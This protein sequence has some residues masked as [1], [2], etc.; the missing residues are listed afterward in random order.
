MLLS[1]GGTLENDPVLQAL[2]RVFPDVVSAVLAGELRVAAPLHNRERPAP[3]ARPEL[4]LDREQTV[5]ELSAVAA[6]QYRA[7][8][9]AHR[10]RVYPPPAAAPPRVARVRGTLLG[11]PDHPVPDFG[12]PGNVA[13]E[14]G[15]IWPTTVTETLQFIGA[16]RLR[17]G[18][19]DFFYLNKVE[20]FP[21]WD[22]YDGWEVVTKGSAR[23]EHLMMAHS[24]VAHM[25]PGSPT[26]FV[27]ID[28]WAAHRD[29]YHMIRKLRFFRDFRRRKALLGW[30]SGHRRMKFNRARDRISAELFTAQ[31]VFGQALVRAQWVLVHLRELRFAPIDPSLTYSVKMMAGLYTAGLDRVTT[32]IRSALADIDSEVAKLEEML[33]TQLAALDRRAYEDRPRD[34]ISSWRVPKHTF[35]AEV[36]AAEMGVARVPTFRRTV[37][38]LFVQEMLQFATRV[39][40]LDLA[41]AINPSTISGRGLFWVLPGDGEWHQNSGVLRPT[42]TE[43]LDIVRNRYAELSSAVFVLCR[44]YCNRH[45]ALRRSHGSQPASLEREFVDAICTAPRFVESLRT[46]ETNLASDFDAVRGMLVEQ[47]WVDDVENFVDD[48]TEKQLSGWTK[49]LP[50]IYDM[51]VQINAWSR[52]LASVGL[53]R[54]SPRMIMCLDNRRNATHLIPRLTAISHDLDALLVVYISSNAQRVQEEIAAN[55]KLL[56]AA[57]SM[58]HPSPV[59]YTRFVAGVASAQGHVEQFTDEALALEELHGEH[60]RIRKEFR[61]TPAG[62]LAECLADLSATGAEFFRMISAGNALREAL[63][64]TM[65]HKL[66]VRLDGARHLVKSIEL[67]LQRPPF[68]CP[69]YQPLFV[70]DELRDVGT[71]M[72]E[73]TLE[74]REIANSLRIITGVTEDMTAFDNGARALDLRRKIWEHVN[75]CRKALNRFLSAPFKD[76]DV[77]LIVKK[78]MGWRGDTHDLL[79][80]QKRELTRITISEIAAAAAATAVTSPLQQVQIA[81]VSL[82]PSGRRVSLDGTRPF[83]NAKPMR[84][85]RGSE[86]PNV[87]AGAIAP[88]PRRQRRGTVL[89]GDS[90]INAAQEPDLPEDAVLLYV[91]RILNDTL[92]I[93]PILSLLADKAIRPR[94]WKTLFT[95]LGR[96]YDPHWKFTI[97]TLKACEI[98]SFSPLVTRLNQLAKLEEAQQRELA[99]IKLVWGSMTIPRLPTTVAIPQLPRAPPSV[100]WQ[101]ERS[102]A[103][104]RWRQVR[105]YMLTAV[106]E[107]KQSRRANQDSFV[108]IT[109]FFG[110]SILGPAGVDLLGDTSELEAVILEHS[111][112]MNQVLLSASI[113]FKTVAEDWLADFQSIRSALA[114][115]RSVED[116]WLALAGY[117]ER[118]SFSAVLGPNAAEF[119]AIDKSY[120]AMSKIIFEKPLAMMLLSYHKTDR[121]Y[122]PLQGDK[123]ADELC[124][125]WSRL[126]V[127][128]KDIKADCIEAA[129]ANSPRLLML[130]DAEL[131]RALA[132]PFVPSSRNHA[133]LVQC[134]NGVLRFGC[135]RVKTKGLVMATHAIYQVDKLI[136]EAGEEVVFSRPIMIAREGGVMQWHG[137][138]VAAMQDSLRQSLLDCLAAV[139]GKPI[140]GLSAT[141]YDA[142]CAAWPSQTLLIAHEVAVVRCVT[143]LYASGADESA[144]DENAVFRDAKQALSELTARWDQRL[145]SI[146]SSTRAN[147]IT[148][149]HRARAQ[150]LF[151]AVLSQRDRLRTL[152]ADD[153]PRPESFAWQRQMRY[154]IE[155]PPSGNR[156]IECTVSCLGARQR[157]SFEF[158]GRAGVRL[159]NTPLTERY[160]L[161]IALAVQG[162]SAPV[163]SGAVGAGRPEMV[164]HAAARLGRYLVE[165]EGSAELTCRTLTR[166]LEGVIRVGAWFLLRSVDRL[167][168]GAQSLVGTELLKL[169]W[170]GASGSR[171]LSWL[172]TRQFVPSGTDHPGIILTAD[173]GSI[174]SGRCIP[175]TD[176]LN[177]I[178]RPIHMVRPELGPVL[179]VELQLAGFE[180]VRELSAKL[181]T[182]LAAARRGPVAVWQPVGLRF[183]RHVIKTAATLPCTKVHPSESSRLREALEAAMPAISGF[184]HSALCEVLDAAFTGATSL[185]FSQSESPI[186]P[187][188]RMA[189]VH[190]T[191]APAVIDQRIRATIDG[192]MA[193]YGLHPSQLQVDKLVKMLRALETGRD[194]L[195]YGPAGAGKTTLLRVLAAVARAQADSAWGETQNPT[196]GSI[197]APPIYVEHLYPSTVGLAALLGGTDPTTGA[198]VDGLIGANVR[199]SGRQSRV[200]RWLVC[201]G[202]LQPAW[203]EVISSAIKDDRRLRLSSGEQLVIPQTVTFMFE[204]GNLEDG[205]PALLQNVSAIHIPGTAVSGSDVLHAWHLSIAADFPEVYSHNLD[206]VTAAVERLVLPTARLLEVQH[207]VE[208]M[209]AVLVRTYLTI[210]A[211]VIRDELELA[212]LNGLPRPSYHKFRALLSALLAFCYINVIQSRCPYEREAEFDR[213]LRDQLGAVFPSLALPATGLLVQCVV[214]ST[215]VQL[216]LPSSPA[217]LDRVAITPTESADTGWVAT[218]DCLSR[219]MLVR[220]LLAS[221]VPVLVQGPAGSGKTA[222]VRHICAATRQP[223]ARYVELPFTSTLTGATTRSMLV[224]SLC[225]HDPAHWHARSGQT[226]SRTRRRNLTMFVDDIQSATSPVDDGG[227]PVEVLRQFLDRQSLHDAHSRARS[228][229]KPKFIIARTTLPGSRFDQGRLARFMRHIFVIRHGYSSEESITAI[230]APMLERWL[231]TFTGMLPA[232]QLASL[233]NVIPH[234]MVATTSA[235]KLVQPVQ[236][237]NGKGG[238]AGRNFVF[239]DLHKIAQIITAVTT[240][241]PSSIPAV[242][243]RNNGDGGGDESEEE[244]WGGGFDFF[245]DD[246]D[247]PEILGDPI[248]DA[249]FLVPHIWCREAR[250]AFGPWF[251]AVDRQAWLNTTLGRCANSIAEA[252]VSSIVAPKAIPAIP[253]PLWWI[254]TNDERTAWQPTSAEHAV[255]KFEPIAATIASADSAIS[256]VVPTGLASILDSVCRALS[257]GRHLILAGRV[258]SSQDVLVRLAAHV[259]GLELRVVHPPKDGD[260]AEFRQ[261][262]LGIT[263]AASRPGARHQ[264][265]MVSA[266][267]SLTEAM[268]SDLGALV[269]HSWVPGDVDRSVMT[270]VDVALRG[271][272]VPIAPAAGGSRGMMALIS[273]AVCV[274]D[275]DRGLDSCS[276]PAILE[277]AP[278]L[279]S[280]AT[281]IRV[282]WD[283]DMLQQLAQGFINRLL[284]HDPRI[285]GMFGGNDDDPPVGATLGSLL[286]HVHGQ[287]QDSSGIGALADGLRFSALLTT[288]VAL[289]Q[290][291]ARWLNH[292]IK[293]ARMLIERVS[294]ANDIIAEFQA[295]IDAVIPVRNAATEKCE[296]LYHAAVAKRDALAAVV[297]R[298]IETEKQQATQRTKIAELRAVLEEKSA[299]C[300]LMI[301][302]AVTGLLALNVH[303][304]IEISEYHQPPA[305]VVLAVSPL[306]LLFR[307]YWPEPVFAASDPRLPPAGAAPTWMEAKLLLGQPKVFDMIAGFDRDNISAQTLA[308]VRK[309]VTAENYVP[310]KLGVASKAVVSLARW[311]I[312]IAEYAEVQLK[313]APHR[314]AL[315]RAQRQL[316]EMDRIVSKTIKQEEKLRIAVRDAKAALAAHKAYRQTVLDD[317]ERI[318]ERQSRAR[319]LF[320]ETSGLVSR[321]REDLAQ[322]ESAVTTL[323]GDAVVASACI[324]YT[325]TLTAPERDQLV[326]SWVL[327]C[328]Q[329]DVPV[330]PRFSLAHVLASDE[331]IKYWGSQGLPQKAVLVDAVAIARSS[332]QWPLIWD[333]YGSAAPLLDRIDGGAGQTVVRLDALDPEL[334]STVRAAME[335][336]HSVLISGVEATV[337]LAEMHPSLAQLLA[338]DGQNSQT[339]NGSR[340]YKI[341]G[342][343]VTV[344]GDFRLYLTRSGRFEA[345]DLT[346]QVCLVDYSDIAVVHDCLLSEASRIEQ[347]EVEEARLASATKVMEFTVRFR[348]NLETLMQRMQH[349]SAS[350]FETNDFT[351][352]ILKI[353]ESHSADRLA[354]EQET[355]LRES[356]EHRRRRHRDVAAHGAALF[357]FATWL[358]P[359]GDNGLLRYSLPTCAQVFRRCL[360]EMKDESKRTGAPRGSSDVL[361]AVTKAIHRWVCAGATNAEAREFA[362]AVACKTLLD[363][364]KATKAEVTALLSPDSTIGTIAGS[365]TNKPDWLAVD[366]WERVLLLAAAV[367]SLTWLPH[368]IQDGELWQEYLDTGPSLHAELPVFQQGRE[369]DSASSDKSRQSTGLRKIQAM[370]VIKAL[371]PAAALDAARELVISVVGPGLYERPTN[372]LSEALSDPQPEAP[373][374]VVL[375]SDGD[376]FFDIMQFAYSS[377]ASMLRKTAS[378]SVTSSRQLRPEYGSGPHNDSVPWYIHTGFESALESGAAVG[379][380]IRNMRSEAEAATVSSSLSSRAAAASATNADAFAGQPPVVIVP[381]GTGENP[382]FGVVLR[383]CCDLG[384]WVIFHNCHLDPGAV[385]IVAREFEALG[386]ARQRSPGFRLWL[387]SRPTDRLAPALVLPAVKLQWQQ[388]LRCEDRHSRWY[389]RMIR[390]PLFGATDANECMAHAERI[391]PILSKTSEIHIPDALQADSE[392]YHSD[393]IFQVGKQECTYLPSHMHFLPAVAFTSLCTLVAGW[394]VQ[395]HPKSLNCCS[396]LRCHI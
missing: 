208:L 93:S 375:S 141:A 86:L 348:G 73:I 57:T 279:G 364:G 152:A 317:L 70:L 194:L 158:L 210:L 354:E 363:A 309:I 77:P 251:E 349:V 284:L 71:R 220:A 395:I 87:L 287:T 257:I 108:T 274:H 366:A 336:G 4:E 116:V 381:L 226:A 374:A 186:H 267:Y 388:P 343:L 178:L 9:A 229:D 106:N 199:H 247:A 41:A 223:F 51:L 255:R 339:S 165:L 191:E 143:E 167:A 164:R 249:P 394:R 390:S 379:W 222:L 297:Q 344:P 296:E 324:V 62:G 14:S 331:S 91:L 11:P 281:V 217:A 365:A 60:V 384:Q 175:L 307:P 376:P 360:V 163:L 212:E 75:I 396:L 311:A 328:Q 1:R 159:V 276:L 172:G 230:F 103:R 59:E 21:H 67:K 265:I 54:P 385:Q 2:E 69:A 128:M 342:G 232:P 126:E 319:R 49:N 187:T 321:V 125:L 81:S 323:V 266:R 39:L 302:R 273:V 96:Q 283:R 33:A 101:D 40:S 72:R 123:F 237:S 359:M 50:G 99:A 137:E 29:A 44:E 80:K 380:L 252:L 149:E 119:I 15:M 228:T 97:S 202:S 320:E 292:R 146:A 238:T 278:V 206:L 370:L 18:D 293:V 306:C 240:C 48:W 174:T 114:L 246:D 6:R 79:K 169:H 131:L 84:G 171:G 356:L 368:A 353:N 362:V 12:L 310:E 105:E 386:S 332:F 243:A 180:S 109:E 373:V 135:A 17:Q 195:I 183:L 185:S 38:T 207:G 20:A 52:R 214:D 268:L 31:P 177:S 288:F 258:G 216:V 315:A 303:D 121:R 188:D 26:E 58:T 19:L 367:D 305:T 115:W 393:G 341:D 66:R 129:R 259:C 383:Q 139:Q 140:E 345:S 120:R 285:L 65:S 189:H 250:Q 241:A 254:P 355:H 209:E 334:P 83:A 68:V 85:R 244:D 205:S 389:S 55:V 387:T 304:I 286:T 145:A 102:R 124:G 391:H 329:C 24:G 200:R 295:Q 170:C 277:A 301:N 35:E 92:A 198:W 160:L 23:P 369:T 234:I 346:R 132:T 46:V 377:W 325:G 264:V 231:G 263:A 239:Y 136:G 242:A 372:L 154:T 8:D 76:V 358:E 213:H 156:A 88:V 197:S 333:P 221:K 3:A 5:A 104:F 94:H 147:G 98:T 299:D 308:S 262:L 190:F 7:L 113:Q 151:V 347:P 338:G 25:I 168:S 260:P 122:R 127:L 45:N 337:R 245:D 203:V 13:L 248:V 155:Q 227:D 330:R 148:A 192:T 224:Q 327:R 162:F 351:T 138:V 316:A 196:D 291:R 110:R 142:F 30:V 111:A 36:V 134:F 204:T 340:T 173:A 378:K 256:A 133:T 42:A 314:E 63:A 176:G 312:A 82:R 166:V 74:A 157:Y 225:E 32:S 294:K 392:I 95:A 193:Q 43:L 118:G 357:Q 150:D 371:K 61:R 16:R 107:S 112:I 90:K 28:V 313:L 37:Y 298:R 219:Q 300:L 64:P 201:D 289:F 261:Q 280:I 290:N 181:T 350:D 100:D 335:A 269:K 47:A 235:A 179:E 117:Y 318:R 10:A 218:P 161:N 153:T 326:A 282:E 34:Y 27:P 184:E 322:M 78:L 130:P 182:F 352:E 253:A 215:A 56:V 275:L 271:G 144:D 270:S 361:A 22:P 211:A 53:F 233:M 236:Y 89:L 382:D 272:S